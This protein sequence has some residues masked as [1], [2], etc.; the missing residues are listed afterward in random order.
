M[1]VDQLLSDLLTP[2]PEVPSGPAY[3]EDRGLTILPDGSVL[4]EARW[5]GD[6]FTK[7]VN[8][9]RDQCVDAQHVT[10]ISVDTEAADHDST[11]WMATQTSV[12][13]ENPDHHDLELLLGTET[14]TDRE[15]PD[16][17]YH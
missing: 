3:C 14:R 2:E 10:V 8:E 16:H 15:E 5:H 4:I 6:T 17:I 7:V 1:F 13:R 9:N 12:R 11:L